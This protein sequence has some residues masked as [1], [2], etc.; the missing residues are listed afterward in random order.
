MNTVL[1]V[2]G[3]ALATLGSVAR[4]RVAHGP[5]H[6]SWS[7]RIEVVA[8]L[9]R[10]MSE[11]SGVAGPQWLRAAH[12]SMPSALP[13]PLRTVRFEAVRADGVPCEWARPAAV[14]AGRPERAI[15]YL[16]GGGYVTGSVLTH[17]E[18]V[19]RLAAGVGVPVL[20]VDYRLAP[21][22][23]YPAA[24][25]DCLRAVRWLRGQG[26]PAARTAIAGDSAG[27]ALAIATMLALRDAGEP[28][29][30][31]AAL[32]CPWVDPLA[33]GGSMDANDRYDIIGR[34]VLTQWARLYASEAEI[35]GPVLTPLS[36]ELAGLPPLIIQWGELEV[37]RD[38]IAAFAERARAAGVAVTAD[39]HPAMFHDFQVLASL[40]PPG[41][42]G[43]E[44]LVRFLATTLS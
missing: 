26:T 27:G 30:A 24:H 14:A 1:E 42:T 33:A 41:V 12:A 8:A 15:V 28:Q 40:V 4:R 23:R 10:R 25:D 34:E 11:R 17:R 21:E 3:L 22:H 9:V 5:R 35:A 32:L 16:H 6:P 13:A 20:S 38:Q 36:A 7:F 29:L 37:L 18:I 39:P 44:R 2:G 43:V 19:A 31:G